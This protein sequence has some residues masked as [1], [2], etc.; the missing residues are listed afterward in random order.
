M[1]ILGYD[2]CIVKC[3]AP[4]WIGGFG[5]HHPKSQSIQIAS[6][7]H[8]QEAIST[9]LHEIIEALNYHLQLSLSHPTIMS[10]EAGLFQ[11]LTDAGVDLS[12]LIKGIEQ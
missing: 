11:V 10:L 7:M 4:D 1:K 12:S 6:E 2:Y 8:E 3:D 9:L 5:R